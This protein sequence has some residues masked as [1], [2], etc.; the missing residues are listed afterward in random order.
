MAGVED[1][2]YGRDNSLNPHKAQSVGR[3]KK[4]DSHSR[5]G[6][7]K[8][9]SRWVRW[10]GWVGLGQRDEDMAGCGYGI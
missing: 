2:V 7:D 6:R 4:W 5:L 10:W 1:G 3:G 9:V 8:W